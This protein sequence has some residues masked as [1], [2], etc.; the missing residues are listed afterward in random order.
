MSSCH[1]IIVILTNCE[2]LLVY[3]VVKWLIELNSEEYNILICENVHFGS[4]ELQFH[5]IREKHDVVTYIPN[6]TASHQKGQ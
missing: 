5:G 3:V 1:T 4:Q 2:H 6:Y